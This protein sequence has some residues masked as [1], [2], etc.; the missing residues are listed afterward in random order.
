LQSRWYRRR[1]HADVPAVGRFRHL[2]LGSD[3]LHSNERG[4]AAVEMLAHLL[5]DLHERLAAGQKAL[6]RLERDSLNREVLQGEVAPTVG[7]GRPL[8]R[9]AAGHLSLGAL[10]ELLE[11]RHDLLCRGL[12]A[13]TRPFEGLEYRREDELDLVRV[14]GLGLLTEELTLQPL[15]LEQDKLVEFL[16]LVPL[17]FRALGTPTKLV[18]LALGRRELSP[19]P[20]DLLVS[21]F[22]GVAHASF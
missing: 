20:F 15:E 9:L 12:S 1:L 2:V 10:A 22:G 8:L 5:A 16:E 7:L 14:D 6:G 19:Q 13:G 4:G 21:R 3:D 18:P 17:V 11:L